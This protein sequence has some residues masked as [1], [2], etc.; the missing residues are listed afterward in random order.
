MEKIEI[1]MRVNLVKMI[2]DGR[3]VD[4][5]KAHISMIKTDLQTAKAVVTPE[6]PVTM[7]I[8]VVVMASVVAMAR[9][10]GSIFRPSI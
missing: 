7:A 4:E 5:V 1:D 6:F 3:P 9:F 2:D 8:I 10:R